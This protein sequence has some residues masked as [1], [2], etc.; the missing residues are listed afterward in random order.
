MI[1]QPRGENNV[2]FADVA[3]HGR[4]T[5]RRVFKRVSTA[6]HLVNEHAWELATQ[7]SESE[8]RVKGAVLTIS[9]D[10][11]LRTECPDVNAFAVAPAVDDLWSHVLG[12]A[13]EGVRAALAY[14]CHAKINHFE[15]ALV[16]EQQVLG[17]EVTV[18]DVKA[19]SGAK[20]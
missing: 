13:A 18:E 6:K 17:L 14:F 11:P 16:A 9:P 8:R 2:A 20:S 7:Y 3:V 1:S 12:G 5:V 4:V 10:F 15:H 19:A